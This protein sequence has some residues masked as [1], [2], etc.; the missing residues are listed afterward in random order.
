MLRDTGRGPVA[1]NAKHTKLAVGKP[2][3]VAG[4]HPKDAVGTA[5]EVIIYA[6]D[7]Y[8]VTYLASFFFYQKVLL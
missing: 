4:K 8:L 5:K 3:A 6:L 1:A 2:V 7:P